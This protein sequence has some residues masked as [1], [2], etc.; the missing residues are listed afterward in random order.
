[1]KRFLSLF[2]ALSIILSASA[3]NPQVL[4]TNAEKSVK[5]ELRAGKNLKKAP[6]KAAKVEFKSFEQKA[7]KKELVKFIAAPAKAKKENFD[8]VADVCEGTDWGTD[9]QYVMYTED[10]AVYAAFDILYTEDGQKDV[11][12]GVTYT[13]EDMDED[14]TFCYLGDDRLS[15]TAAT[16]T[17]TVDEDGTHF[18]ATATDD[19]ENVI[20]ITFEEAPFILT[21]DTIPVTITKP[22]QIKYYSSSLGTGDWYITAGDKN[23]SVGID[24]YSEDSISPV[25]V[26]DSE[27]G[28]FLLDY[29]AI[30]IDSTELEVVAAQAAIFESN[31]S[32]FVEAFLTAE[33]GNVYA[34]ALF[35]ITP[36][37]AA[38]ETISGN[39]SVTKESFLGL[40]TY[41]V[42]T[43]E[44]EK[45]AISF[46]LYEDD[47]FGTWAAGDDITG[48]V[49]PVDG[50]ESEFFNGQINIEKN[51]S[52]FAVTG[53]VLCFNNIEYTLDLTYAKPESTR[54][55]VLIIDGLKLVVFDDAWQL[56]GYNEDS[57]KFV[58]IAAYTDEITG[59]YTEEDLAAD[60]TYVVTDIDEKGYNYFEMLSAD[61]TVQFSEEDSTIIIAGNLLGQNEEDVPLFTVLLK[62]RIPAPKV[63]DMTFEITNNGE[64][65]IVT[66]SNDE[67]PWD[68]AIFSA[69]NFETYYN[70][71]ADAAAQ[72][73]YDYYGDSYAQPGE[74]SFDL[75]E[76]LEQLGEGD[77]VLIVYGCDG[78]VTTPA[79]AFAFTLS[80]EQGIENI[81]LTEKVQKVV[82]DGAVYV[83]RDNKMF[84]VLGTQVR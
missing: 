76:M 39:V 82:V 10:E 56:A 75:A 48:A 5:K 47:Y 59:N 58:S 34:V 27:N 62:G 36:V 77:F 16:F 28:D 66:P 20:T 17:K 53:K 55:E 14:Y 1:M 3:V 19:A 22:C 69:A 54:E 63:S 83:I 37:K 45:N 44:D 49:T 23:A 52:G 6:A 81:V 42:F 68:Y 72:A 43:A 8:F 12:P 41:F 51:D 25:G 18:V 11:V 67:D 74:D 79:V 73:A 64:A 35:Y 30:E 60:Y 32:L 24:V 2:C 65:I 61:L 84:N 9:V 26:Y 38:E 40:I 33:D 70:N 50:E 78:G 15:L 71:D 4:K 29:T 7:A 21:G 13:L 80:A 31:D 46:T 57:T